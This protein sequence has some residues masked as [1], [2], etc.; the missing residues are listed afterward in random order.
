MGKARKERRED[1]IRR[2]REKRRGR[3]KKRDGMGWDGI[4]GGQ[5]KKRKGGEE[6]DS[7]S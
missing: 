1:G 7:E 6:D 2:E 4:S 5:G 3:R